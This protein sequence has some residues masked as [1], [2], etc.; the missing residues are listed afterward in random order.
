VMR[1]LPDKRPAYR[2]KRIANSIIRHRTRTDE[3]VG[4]NWV[5]RFLARHEDQLHTYWTKHLP[6]NCAGAVNPTN[7]HSWEDIVEEEV[8][9]PGVRP[10]DMYGMDETHMPPEFAQMQQVI[11]GGSLGG[12]CLY[13]IFGFFILLPSIY[14]I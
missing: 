9:V 5:E 12:G 1:E 6:S 3:R 10:E 13:I 8:V 14:W 4:K 2:V 11:S 7:V